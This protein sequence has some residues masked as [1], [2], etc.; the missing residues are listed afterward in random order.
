M[1]P[2]IAALAALL[3]ACVGGD[4]TAR[5]QA[6]AIAGDDGSETFFGWWDLALERACRFAADYLWDD[7]PACYPDLAHAVVVS[8]DPGCRD[9]ALIALS[10][11]D[12]FADATALIDEQGRLYEIGERFEGALY[13]PH[14]DCVSLGALSGVRAG[15]PLAAPMRSS[16]L[17]TDA[18]ARERF[19]SGSRL[20]ARVIESGD[21]AVEH[22]GWRDVELGVSCRFERDAGVYRCVPPLSAAPM[23]YADPDCSGDSM[24][25]TASDGDGVVRLSEG[26]FALGAR[27][28]GAVYQRDPDSACTAAGDALD[29]ARRLRPV[30][31]SIFVGGRLDGG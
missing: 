5:L 28:S 23:R 20:R 15:A 24:V 22:L 4:N 27:Y 2:P 10:D 31:R 6:V 16:E 26:L 9:P 14:G 8:T 25:A 21:G 30:D 17:G 1:R 18:R 7:E 3:A 19:R 11:Q 13:Y 12:G 29:A